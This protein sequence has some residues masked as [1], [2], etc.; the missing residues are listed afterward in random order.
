MG[1]EFVDADE[2]DGQRDERALERDASSPSATIKIVAQAGARTA[3]IA[4]ILPA[5]TATATTPLVTSRSWSTTNVGAAVVTSS[6][7]AMVW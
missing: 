3:S 5:V 4:S 1:D 7:G 6:P 2:D